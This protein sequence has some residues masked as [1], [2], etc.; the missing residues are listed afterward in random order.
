[1]P[2]TDVGQ[3]ERITAMCGAGIPTG[4]GAALD[5]RC[6]EARPG[7]SEMERI[8]VEQPKMIVI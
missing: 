6:G 4:L 7:G 1:M 3:I 2:I 5:S 8:A